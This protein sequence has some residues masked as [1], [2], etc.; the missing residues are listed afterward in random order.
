M[1]KH[2]SPAHDAAQSSLQQGEADLFRVLKRHTE[3][4]ERGTE[5]SELHSAY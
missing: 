3:V 4:G 1:P 2:S 5:G